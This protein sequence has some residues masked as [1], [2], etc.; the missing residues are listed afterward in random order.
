MD[1]NLDA[2][3]FKKEKFYLKRFIYP[4][5]AVPGFEARG[6]SENVCSKQ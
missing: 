3:G 4:E 2:V 6:L 5:N 1:S